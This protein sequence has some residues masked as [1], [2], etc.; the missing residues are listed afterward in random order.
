MG[1]RGYTNDDDRFSPSSSSSSCTIII[2]P[3]IS[4]AR[5]IFIHLGIDFFYPSSIRQKGASETLI[6][7][8]RSSFCLDNGDFSNMS[9][10]A[11]LQYRLGAYILSCIHGCVL[12]LLGFI[13]ETHGV[14]HL[15]T[16]SPAYAPFLFH[17]VLRLHLRR[18]DLLSSKKAVFL[19]VSW[20]ETISLRWA[21]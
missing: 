19:V 17:S 15:Q 20:P 7:R 9:V 13:K 10:S 14:H 2:G 3:L 6:S 16:I 5:Q 1:P 4:C 11:V 21:R 18:Y 8:R 12:Y